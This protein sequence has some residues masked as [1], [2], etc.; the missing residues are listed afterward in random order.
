MHGANHERLTDA[1]SM[2]RKCVEVINEGC[3][4][5][6]IKASLIHLSRNSGEC[7]LVRS[8]PCIRLFRQFNVD[9]RVC[10]AKSP[11]H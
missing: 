9:Q 2:E 7:Q 8:A 5:F 3:L 10:T 4:H 11:N 6:Y 1:H